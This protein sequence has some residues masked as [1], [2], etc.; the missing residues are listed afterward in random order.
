MRIVLNTLLVGYSFERVA[1]GRNPARY[2]WNG[3]RWRRASTKTGVSVRRYML[4]MA[5]YYRDAAAALAGTPTGSGAGAVRGAPPPAPSSGERR[6]DG[7]GDGSP[8]LKKSV[9]L[10]DQAAAAAAAA[11]AAAPKRKV[12]RKERNGAR[13][14]K[15]DIGCAGTPE[16]HDLGTQGFT[17]TSRTPTAQ[18]SRTA[19]VRKPGTRMATL[20]SKC[21]GM[22]VHEGWRYVSGFEFGM[23]LEDWRLLLPPPKNGKKNTAIPT[24]LISGPCECC[25]AQTPYRCVWCGRRLCVNPPKPVESNGFCLP[26]R[27]KGDRFDFTRPGATAASTVYPSCFLKEHPGAWAA[28]AWADQSIGPESSSPPP[29]RKR[30]RKGAGRRPQ[31]P[32]FDNEYDDGRHELADGEDMGEMSP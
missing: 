2:D 10:A 27:M 29:K 19:E 26:A 9:R 31:Q 17:F 21:P 20:A 25:G 30:R 6:A 22:P 16:R 3:E 28:V 15:A 11:T 32:Q 23:A 4:R 13:S 1:A 24:R 7:A 5:N 14:R 8:A 18:T 12:S